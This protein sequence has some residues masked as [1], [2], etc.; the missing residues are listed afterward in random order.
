MVSLTETQQRYIRIGLDKGLIQIKNSRITY[1][2]QKKTYNFDDPE[3]PVR[4]T[5]YVKLVIEYKYPPERIDIELTPPRRAPKF[6]ADI[7]VFKD[8]EH[9]KAF[10][11]VECKADSSEGS[12]REAKKEG[13][14]NANLFNAPYLL[15]A[16]GEEES[17]YDVRKHPSNWEVLD[18]YR[19]SQI[20]IRYGQPPKYRYKKEASG[21]GEDDLREV[22]LNEL[23]A[24]FRKCH[25]TIWEGG[26]RDPAEAFSEMCKLIFAKV[27]DERFTKV[28]EF[29]K[30]QV[31]SGESA[32]TVAER[33][34][35]RYEEVQKK[36]PNVFSEEL[37]VSDGIIFEV[38]KILQ[39]IS[40]IRT[41]LDA[42]GR[43]YEEFLGKVFRGEM[44]QY[45]TPREIVDFMVKFIDPDYTDLV[46]DPACGSSGFLLYS[47]KH[48]MEKA[49]K[50]YNEE[51]SK[52]IIWEFSHRNIFG[53]E[54]NQRIAR[55]A[56]MDMIIH[57]DGHTN[58]ECNDALL[59]YS[60]FDPRRDIKAGKYDILLTNPP[61][62]AKETREKILKQ[63]VLGS[64][65]TMRKSQMKEVLFIERCLELLKPGGRMGIILPDGI[66]KNSS[67]S[68]VQK[69]IKEKA[70]VIAVISLPEYAFVP[71]GS[72]A[73]TSILFLE[74]KGENNEEEYF[75]FYA[76]A[77]YIGYDA[78]GRPDKND[79][80][81][82]LEEWM[83]FKQD[84]NNYKPCICDGEVLSYGVESK[85]LQDR[86]DF[87]YY[88][89]DFLKEIRRIEDS[90][91]RV[92]SLEDIADVKTGKTLKRNQYLEEGSVFNIKVVNITGKGLSWT[93]SHTGSFTSDELYEQN[94]NACVKRGDILM[95]CSAHHVEYIGRC[96]IVEKFPKNLKKV[97]CS[98]EVM[99]IRPNTEK[100]D[101]YYL[102]YY[103]RSKLG[104]VQIRRMITGQ[105]AHLYPDDMKKYFR[106]ILPPK[107]IQQK[108]RNK[109]KKLFTRRK[110]LIG[111]LK[112]L[113][114]LFRVSY[115]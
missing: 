65:I 47:I 39:D 58:I 2:H 80:P 1:T 86:L 88:H 12:I 85:Y 91:W 108:L 38:V 37:K 54:I 102:L 67:L 63:F 93:S 35:S 16:C 71:F 107:D 44:G 115:N 20:P 22:S 6:P 23:R 81:K 21:F 114:D 48:I 51:G 97:M 69:F 50:E 30:F 33:I 43:A 73:K 68:Y 28:G 42:K 66:L 110:K 99:I 96:D 46:I 34:R 36:E 41:D 5:T 11:V 92:V 111:K 56:M 4:A 18:K 7:V 55:V 27:Y 87:D 24:K 59:P 49:A 25:D 101:P 76:K 94:P 15:L 31:G 64:K 84:P 45:F 3:E 52:E 57:E 79:L 89:P 53:I 62:G 112:R 74:K 104:R 40:L 83:R 82:I 19:I 109:I 78:T 61:F 103:L 77:R 105:S 29:Y 13:L 8:E 60:A 98:G 32:K 113:E 17:A 10:I 72:R 106:V 95:V 70:K 9:E 100:V 75:V 14:G 90:K 26:K